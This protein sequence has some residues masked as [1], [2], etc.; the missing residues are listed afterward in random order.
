MKYYFLL[1]LGF[2]LSL[3]SCLKDTGTI[4]LTY[5]EAT[6]LYGDL[7]D[8]RNTPLNEQ[9]RTIENPGK[10]YVSSDHVFIG[11][12][13]KG[14]HVYGNVDASLSGALGFINIPGNREFVVVDNFLYAESYYD[15]VKLDISNP[16]QVSLV[17]RA[18]SVFAEEYINGSG[19][20]LLGFDF[21]QV[22]KEVDESSEI[23]N[24]VIKSNY[25]YLDFAQNI[26]PQSALPSSFAGNSN[27]ASGTV[28]R[29]AFY[30][31]HVYIAG[32]FDINVLR[33][34]GGL[35]FAGRVD[36]AGVEM[37]TIFPYKNNLFVGSRSSMDIFEIESS[38]MPKRKFS[39]EHATSCDPV[40]PCED[41][42]Y[43]SLRTADFSDCP[44][45]IN[46]LIILDI[47]DLASPEEVSEIEMRSPYGM[48]VIDGK[49]YVGEG[50][51]GLSIFDAE[52]K[53]S[54]VEL[55]H[56]SDIQAYDILAHPDRSDIILIAGPDGLSEYQVSSSNELDL[57]GRIDF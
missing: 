16:L 24:E 22:S 25:V 47:S 5:Y 12:E 8:I 54:P 13:G 10:I 49:L 38:G 39:F 3:Q 35:E 42:A 14:I 15:V 19:E 32:R 6:A 33:D 56:I 37:E 23:Y 9:A 53:L 51:N 45:N 7:D 52:D 11:E 21:K 30:E 20:T 34:N 26:I 44:G 31:G 48:A 1:L 43:I 36:N 41:A 27:S 29:L 4:K 46:A 57:Q 40:L 55:T 18:Q 2:V 28:N 17:D 50:E